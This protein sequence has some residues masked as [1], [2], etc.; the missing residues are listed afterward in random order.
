MKD[1][2]KYREM[3]EKDLKSTL[4]ELQKDYFDTK[5]Q[6]SLGKLENTALLAEKRRTIAQVKTLIQE[7]QWQTQLQGDK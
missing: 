2:S 1:L 4:V 3:Q 7:I 6:L 5:L